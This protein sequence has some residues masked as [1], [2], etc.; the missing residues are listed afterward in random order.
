MGDLK[1]KMRKIR[2][3]KQNVSISLSS[4]DVQTDECMCMDVSLPFA[5]GC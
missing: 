2:H 3:P 4:I 5:N 1:I